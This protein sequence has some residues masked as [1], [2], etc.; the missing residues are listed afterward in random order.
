MKFS[1]VFILS[2]FAL[3]TSC[4]AILVKTTGEQGIQENPQART[5]PTVLEDQ[6]IETK[7]IVNMKSQQPE[8]KQSR[9]DVI[10]HNGIVLLVGQVQSEELKF[11]ATEIAGNASSKVRKIYNEL[12][13]TGKTT[14]ITRTNDA[15]ISTKVR[16]QM[17]ASSAIPFSRIKVITENGSVYLMGLVN[18][19]EAQN[20]TS[21]VSNISGVNRVVNVFEY[22]N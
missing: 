7:I 5:F 20:A 12:E 10:S 2:L 16:T 4:T 8:F 15:W 18:R 1:R 9:F 6:S 17:I 19:E 22:T 21:L 3:L 13:V 11:L 14:M